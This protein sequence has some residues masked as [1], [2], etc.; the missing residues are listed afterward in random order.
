MGAVLLGARR[1]AVEFRVIDNGIGIPDAEK[2]RVLDPFYQIDASS[3]RRQG[4]AGLGLSIAKRL[5]DAHEG[6]LV[7]ED[8]V[9]AGTVLV[10]TLP[11]R[12]ASVA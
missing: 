5:V 4:G 3:T 6:T 7:I 2:P 8:N 11:A 9:P 12:R 1:A 10:V